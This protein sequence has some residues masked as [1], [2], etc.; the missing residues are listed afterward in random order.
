MCKVGESDMKKVC[1]NCLEPKQVFK[2]PET[3]Q[4][5]CQ[6][7]WRKKFKHGGRSRF[8]MPKEN[9][10]MGDLMRKWNQK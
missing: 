8:T 2:D 3:G 9:P 4:L 5:I 10:T 6:P 7:C 1:Y